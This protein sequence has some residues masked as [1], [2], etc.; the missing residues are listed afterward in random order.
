MNVFI[1]F[2][3]VRL[4]AAHSGGAKLPL[5]PDLPNRLAKR[6]RSTGR[7]G[8]RKVVAPAP[9][10]VGRCG[11]NALPFLDGRT[12]GWDGTDKLFSTVDRPFSGPHKPFF[13]PDNPLSKPDMDNSATEKPLSRLEKVISAT[14]NP[15]SVTQK[16]ISKPDKPFSQPDKVVSAAPKVLLAG[17][18][19]HLEAKNL[20]FGL[21]A[22][23]SLNPNPKLQPWLGLEFPGKADSIWNSRT[24]ENR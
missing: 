17:D 7:H 18:L 20:A 5:G 15:F 16:V 22:T 6:H 2:A 10:R 24:Q 19:P 14:D 12:G 1:A 4:T 13:T 23:F 3:A 21:P 8:P 11:S 9:R